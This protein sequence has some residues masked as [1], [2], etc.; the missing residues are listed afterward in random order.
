MPRKYV[1]SFGD[2][3]AEGRG[4][5]QELLGGKGAGLAEMTEVGIPVPPGFTITTTACNLYRES[6][7]IPAEVQRQLD[8]HLEL[9]QER[10]G[11]K[12][13]DASDP[14]WFRCDPAQRSRCPE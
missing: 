6:G 14:C 8:E 5:M 2:G 4:D 9:L 11:K 12:L 10:M 1:Y 7:T 3:V 13:G